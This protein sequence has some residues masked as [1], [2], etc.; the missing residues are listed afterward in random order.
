MVH[1]RTS[2]M[3]HQRTSSMV[4]K[5][6]SSMVPSS[7]S[8][9]LARTFIVLSTKEKEIHKSN[10]KSTPPNNGTQL[11]RIDCWCDLKSETLPSNPE[12][13]R[14]ACQFLQCSKKGILTSNHVTRPHNNL[15]F[16]PV[17]PPKSLVFIWTHFPL[18]IP[19]C[20]VP[21]SP[22]GASCEDLERL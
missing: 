22:L 16:F 6:T 14:N 12:L 21:F 13:V 2:S 4:H 9:Q 7:T 5:R 18:R 19:C 11:D 3:V 15:C 17:S 8:F 10:E 20:A 1:Q